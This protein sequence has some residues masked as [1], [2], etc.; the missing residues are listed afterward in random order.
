[1]E[2]KKSRLGRLALFFACVLALGACFTA[3]AFG[4]SFARPDGSVPVPSDWTSKHVLFPAGFT[5]EQ[6]AK[7]RNEP[8]A[9]AQW[10]RHD[11]ERARSTWRRKLPKWPTPPW[12]SSRE[13]GRDWAVSLAPGALLRACRPPST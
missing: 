2:L 7:M 13:M 5:E 12:R 4:Q 6:A 1:M 3:P 8:R 11:D 10:L 9:Y